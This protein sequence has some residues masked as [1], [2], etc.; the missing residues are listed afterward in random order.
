MY[1]K[2]AS[3]ISDIEVIAK[4]RSVRQR[5][6]LR[7]EYGGRRWRKLKGFALVELRDGSTSLAEVHWFEAHSVGGRRKK[8]KEL[9]D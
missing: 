5:A 8:V 6:Q 4:G 7:A 3:E 2:L 1:F 9:L